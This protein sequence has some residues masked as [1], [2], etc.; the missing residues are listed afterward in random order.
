MGFAL[1]EALA[2]DGALVNLVSGP[3]SCSTDHNSI[4]VFR[5]QTAQEMYE[6]CKDLFPDCRGAILSA[7][8]ADYRP[9][10][11][12]N[13][14]IK[15]QKLHSFDMELE[16]TPDILAYLGNNKDAG[17]VVAGFS[18]ESEDPEANAIA[19]LRNKHLDLVVLNRVDD[20]GSNFGDHSIPFSVIDAEE[21]ISTYQ[22][23][24][25]FEMAKVIVDHFK[26]CLSPSPNI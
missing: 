10:N 8:V 22:A 18:L 9:K 13:S 24:P 11:P 25:K 19:K 12:K 2:Q 6:R 3:S 17:Q 16:Q 14:K 7:A 15:K 20:Q 26:N 23:L 5:V 1:A 21:T 4:G